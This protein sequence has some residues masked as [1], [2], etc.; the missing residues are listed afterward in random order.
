M[1]KKKPGVNRLS[2]IDLYVYLD[3]SLFCILDLQFY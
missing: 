1:E 2:D 3:G